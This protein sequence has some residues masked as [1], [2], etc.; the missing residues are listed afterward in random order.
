MGDQGRRTGEM[1]T[2]V[3]PSRGE[4]PGPRKRESSI[5]KEIARA[6]RPR[7][8]KRQGKTKKKPY[9]LEKSFKNTPEVST[10]NQSLVNTAMST[11]VG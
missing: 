10:R 1:I 2:E 6:A 4:G 9:H 8:N 11:P 7:Q 5:K 3:Q